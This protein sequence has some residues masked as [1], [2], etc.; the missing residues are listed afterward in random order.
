MN[1]GPTDD[2]ERLL[3]RK[4]ELVSS[5]ASNAAFEARLKELRQWQAARL[6]RTYADLHE[7]AR[8]APAVEFFLTDLYGVHDFAARDREMMR[9]W[10]YFRRSL[11]ESP[12]RALARAI[13]LDV[14]TEEL[15]RAMVAA[16]PARPLDETLY[17][18][19]YRSVA[20][21]PARQRQIDLVV[22]AG[23]DLDRAVRHAWVGPL[24][25][26]TH[27]PA[28]AAGFGVLQDFIERGYRAFKVMA[29]ADEFLGTIRARETVLME[30]LFS[31][32]PNPFARVGTGKQS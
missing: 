23:E 27:A 15:D 31:R 17:A 1:A 2:L 9:A 22:S 25:A 13:D 16:L 5:G 7:N 21:R 19:A 6:A 14:L 20:R 4:H 3:E 10:R 11:P 32:T 12:R 30:A 29:G 26:A 24:L 28:R 18:E 8:Y